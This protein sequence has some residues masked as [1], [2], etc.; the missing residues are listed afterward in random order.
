MVILADTEVLFGM[1]KDDPQY[2]S[3]KTILEIAGREVLIPQI[4][5]LEFILVI[6]SQQLETHE[7]E[8]LIETV[9]AILKIYSVQQS[10]FSLTQILEGIKIHRTVF[11]SQKGKFFDS[12]IIGT[13]LTLNLAILGN[14]RVF[15]EDYVQKKVPQLHSLTFQQFLEEKKKFGYSGL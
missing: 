7:L 12:L 8:E 6:N 2:P 4:A 15:S 14:D 3:L 9:E 10:S 11:K 1:N 13:A 5:F